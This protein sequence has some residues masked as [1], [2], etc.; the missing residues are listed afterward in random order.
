MQYIK[1]RTTEKYNRAH[2]RTGTYGM[3]GLSAG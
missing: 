2:G 3:R 1:A